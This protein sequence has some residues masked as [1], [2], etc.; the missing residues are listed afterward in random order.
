MTYPE[1]PPCPNCEGTGLIRC[2]I[3][4]PDGTFEDRMPPLECPDC[5]GT[6]KD[7]R[8]ENAPGTSGTRKK[9]IR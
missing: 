8:P 2:G 6:G 3:Q 5:L 9:V 1:R 7:Y 4:Y